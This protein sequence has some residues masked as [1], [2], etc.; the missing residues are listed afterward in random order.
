MKKLLSLF[1]MTA[2]V[3]LPIFAVAEDANDADLMP[4]LVKGQVSISRSVNITDNEEKVSLN[5]REAS[6]VDVLNML[7]KQGNFNLIMD[8]SV[9]GTLSV[10]IKD[11]SVNKALEYI[12]TV[13]NLSY[14]RDGNTIIVASRESANQMNLNARTFKTLPVRYKSAQMIVQQLN[15]TIF[16][17]DRPGGRTTALAAADP[18][19]NSL[20]IIGTDED[21]ALVKEALQTLDVPRNRKVYQIKYSTP[22]YV[23][24]VLSANFF[25][26]N[27]LL[28][29]PGAGGQPGGLGQGGLTG[30]AGGL[31]QGGLAGQAGGLG[32]G[33]LAGQ[34][35]GLGQGGL[36][37]QAGGLGQG[38]LGGQ[39]G[40][41][42][43]GGLGQGGLGGLTQFT[44]GG[45][46]FIAEPISATLTVIGT[47]EQLALVDSI[48]DQVDVRRPQAVIEVS[49][50]EIQVSELKSFQP[51]WG[52]FNLGEES[53]IDLN[54][55]SGGSPTGVNQFSFN[56]AGLSTFSQ[57]NFLSSFTL[58]QSHQNIKGKVLANP[59]IVAMDGLES[60]ISITDQ[61]ANVQQTITTTTTGNIITNQ[62]TTQDAG[63]SLSVTPTITNDGS[64]ALDLSPEVSQPSR[65][66]TA[67][68][69]STTLISTRSMT[70]TGVRVKD[71]QTL[72]IGG[73]I[74]ET[75]SFDENKIPGL[76]KL[77]IV[78]A[79]FRTINSNDRNKTELVLMVTPHILKEDAV[80]YFDQN[81]Q[82]QENKTR[83]QPNRVQQKT[84]TRGRNQ[85]SNNFLTVEARSKKS[86]PDGHDQ[87]GQKK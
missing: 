1:L 5:L 85:V 36:A 14:S 17:V 56:K 25:I 83:I 49:L 73:L 16:Q 59:T 82:Q 80:S 27:V 37:G 45:V 63:I 3:H 76:D 69:T 23:A 20:L 40:G 78:R 51:L 41:L 4:P 24:Q 77:P 65:T 34:A 9:N 8:E 28:G 72:V 75:T 11:V 10:D 64:I 70:L 15:S 43:Q 33:G 19:S 46:T 31:G 79:M 26:E 66:I 52:A 35:G 87:T 7:A 71:G 44:T 86:T 47:K 42:G 54:V 32:Q 50:V 22:A 81:K 68:E 30:Q 61:I 60:N 62:I 48:I 29:A 58:S 13:M 67:G 57:N 38:G 21:I 12:F 18:D 2:L 84:V 55:V 53:A 39:A 74:N 6:L